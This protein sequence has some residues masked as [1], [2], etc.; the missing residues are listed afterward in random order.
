MLE[1][2]VDSFDKLTTT[3]KV[4]IGVA[5]GCSAIA[6]LAA[7]TTSSYKKKPTTLQ[8]SGGSIDPSKV[9][10]EF[11]TYAKSY[12]T[13]AGVGMTD[14]SKTVHLVD[15]FYSLVTDL[16]EWGWGQ[17][18]HFSP[19]LPGKSWRESEA[20]HEARI[21]GLLRLKPGMKVIDCGC[22][23]GGPLRTIAST[24]GSHVTGLTIN[25]Y[26]V[27]RA[28]LHNSRVRHQ[29]PCFLLPCASQCLPGPSSP[30]QRASTLMLLSPAG[31]DHTLGGDPPRRLHQNGVCPQHL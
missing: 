20:A 29:P 7:V 24:S 17:S 21:A 28:E 27:S 26:Q 5:G 14:R 10:S 22:G 8:L 11:D 13:E 16:Y 19:R 2:A 23:V 15:V 4:V 31:R 1:S 25:E 3:Q 18:F 6:I 12:S 9:K 30:Q